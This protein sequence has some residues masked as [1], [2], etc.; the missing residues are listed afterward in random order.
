MDLEK[1][2]ITFAATGGLSGFFPQVSPEQLYGMELDPYAHE[3][4]QVVVWIGYIQ[5][6]Y[7]NGFGVPSAPI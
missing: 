4:A 3:L 7:D 1:A 2:V 5:W 6:L